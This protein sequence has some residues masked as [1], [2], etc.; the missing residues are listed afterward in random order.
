MHP[1]AKVKKVLIAIPTIGKDGQGRLAGV[2][3]WLGEGRY[4]DTTLIRAR[5]DFTPQAVRLALRHGIDGAILAIP[6]CPDACAI[7]SKSAI[8]IAMMTTGIPPSLK[9]RKP[10]TAFSLVDNSAIGSAAARH[11]LGFG[12]FAS[13]VYVHD[14]RQSPWSMDRL[15][16]FATTLRTKGLTCSVFAEG[17]ETNETIDILPREKLRDFIL[18]QPRPSAVFAANDI[19]AEQIISVCRSAN[20]SIPRQISVLG[21]D[22]DALICESTRP[23]LSSIAPDFIEAG[24]RAADLLDRM[25][26]GRRPKTTVFHANV[27][28]IITRDSTAPLTPATKIVA[29]ALSFIKAK[30]LSGITSADVI[31]HLRVSRSLANLRFRELRGESIG[32]ALVRERLAH[33]EKLLAGTTWSMKRIAAECGYADPNVFRNLFRAHHGQSMS[34]YRAKPDAC[35]KATDGR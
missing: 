2:F 26:S 18:H 5:A 13:Y 1:T 20:L 6:Y 33:A 29:D 8:P 17:G 24:Y 16:G 30:A 12:M 4:W 25:M 28:Q 3:R 10:M 7:L 22:N 21:V 14:P 23:M 34:A 31:A 11:F 19:I 15:N 27:S 32:E 9:T 35:A